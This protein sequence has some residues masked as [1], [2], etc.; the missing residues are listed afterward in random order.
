MTYRIGVAVGVAA[1]ARIGCTPM[2]T[3]PRLVCD[4]CGA[5]ESVLTRHG[6]PKTSWLDAHTLRGWRTTRA[7][8]ADGVTRH[9]LC[10]ACARGAR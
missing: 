6:Q 3:S 8:T 1:A 5:T 2:C 7:E 4:Q 9:D 10:P